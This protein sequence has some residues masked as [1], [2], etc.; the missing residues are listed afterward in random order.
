MS[1]A[2]MAFQLGE[3]IVKGYFNGHKTRNEIAA[4]FNSIIASSKDSSNLCEINVMCFFVVIIYDFA[5]RVGSLRYLFDTS[6]RC[7]TR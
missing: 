1:R 4:E 2:E 3:R 5:R 7:D 6:H